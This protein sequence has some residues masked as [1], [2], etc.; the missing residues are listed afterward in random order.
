A[1]GPDPSDPTARFI[2]VAVTS[3]SDRD[4][5]DDRPALLG[6][7]WC[8]AKSGDGVGE[9][10]TVELTAP[11][12][13][14]W[15]RVTAGTPG[16][17]AMLDGRYN[18]PTALTLTVDD[19]PPR[20]AEASEDDGIVE[21]ELTP[22]RT[23]H[24]LTITIDAVT[25]APRRDSCVTGLELG[26]LTPVTIPVDAVASYPAAVAA[27]TAALTSCDR[28]ALAAVATF[29]Y[30]WRATDEG[31]EAAKVTVEKDVKA[32]VRSCEGI[33]ESI[34]SEL[35]SGGSSGRAMFSGDGVEIGVASDF[36]TLELRWRGGAWKLAG[37]HIDLL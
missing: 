13:L 25:R 33:P 18:R 6:R 4:R 19:E 28:D 35:T 36:M 17:T 21:W 9:A 22:P 32:L 23:V 1:A 11:T 8:E 24:R 7:P 34:R 14:S 20:R 3:T 29:P 16:E 26:D 2:Q 30:R 31:Y 27:A 12:T 37:S 5:K 15:I 10:V